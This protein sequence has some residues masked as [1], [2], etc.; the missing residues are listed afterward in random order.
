MTIKI[1]D[2]V[3]ETIGPLDKR[4]TGV[5]INIDLWDGELSNENHGTIEVMVIDKANSSYLDNGDV[6]H[7]SYYGWQDCL[8]II[9]KEIN[10]AL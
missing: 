6:E 5:V 7:Y 2:I 4:I 10:N 1:W 8:E 9:K 3:K